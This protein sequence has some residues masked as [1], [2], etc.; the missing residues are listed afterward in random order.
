MATFLLPN[1]NI[2]EQK[3]TT[4][5]D[6]KI[7]NHSE[8]VTE[9]IKDTDFGLN[10]IT[11]LKSTYPDLDGSAINITQKEHRPEL[12]DNDISSSIYRSFLESTT[13]TFHATQVATIMVGRGISSPMNTGVVPNARLFSVSFDKTSPEIDKFYLQNKVSVVNNSFGTEIEP[14]YGKNAADY[15]AIVQRISSLFFIFSAGNSGFS[16]SVNGKYANLKGISNLTGNYKMAKNILTVGAI[17]QYQQITDISSVG[18]AYDGRIK[19]EV[20]AFSNGGTSQAAALASGIVAMAQQFFQKMYKEMPSVALLKALLI[21]SSDDV[22]AIGIDHKTGF[23]SINASAIIQD[24]EKKT[25]WESSLSTNEQ[26]SIFINIPENIEQIKITLT[27]SDLPANSNAPKALVNDLDLSLTTENPIFT[28]WQPWVLSHFPHQDSLLKK[29]I[30][31]HDN[32]NNIEQITLD[33]PKAGKYKILVFGN[34]ILSPSQNF[35]VAYRLQLSKQFSWIFPVRDSKIINNQPKIIR[36]KSTLTDVRAKLDY[37][38]ND[39]KTWINLKSD[40]NLKTGFYSWETPNIFSEVKLRLSTS[41]QQFISD[42]FIISPIIQANSLFFC[43]DSTQLFWNEPQFGLDGVKYNVYQLDKMNNSWKRK[44]TLTKLNTVLH[45]TSQNDSFSIEPILPSG[46]TGI[47]SD[48]IN[49][50]NSGV[51]CFYNDFSSVLEDEKGKLLLKLTTTLGIKNLNFLKVT[52]SGLKNLSTVTVNPNIQDYT[53][54]D[55]QLQEGVN[56]YQVQLNFK[57]GKTIY[58]DISVLFYSDTN[59]FWLFPNP[60]QLNEHL[61]VQSNS[62][63]VSSFTLFNVV[64]STVLEQP[65]YYGR[66]QLNISSLSAGNYYF[67][68]YNPESLKIKKGKI[69]VIF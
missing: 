5:Y 61:I 3:V 60:L 55:M 65:I 54:F 2:D 62:P 17:N 46:K 40:I 22:G 8:G 16:N 12:S 42:S 52:D 18:P 67:R 19:P 26:K 28:I 53:F 9:N 32:L 35:A 23:G 56:K 58:S 48:I 51:S 44:I 69:T 34:K 13:T 21:N 30:R 4:N 41:N 64:G 6:R 68:I 31:A 15:D 24:I 37:S 66:N 38:L 45:N 14:F 47:R 57:N 39:G 7:K 29:P 20:V 11:L 59:S 25:F 33:K 10:E 43:A 36:W 49:T 63:E 1:I 27:W 50:K